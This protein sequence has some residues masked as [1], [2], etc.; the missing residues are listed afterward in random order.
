M[1]D[2]DELVQ[3]VLLNPD[4]SP[5]MGVIGQSPLKDLSGFHPTVSLPGDIMH[6]FLEGICPMVMMSLLKQASSMHLITYGE[7]RSSS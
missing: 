5:L 3:E 1:I 4:L 7:K 6:D 2:H